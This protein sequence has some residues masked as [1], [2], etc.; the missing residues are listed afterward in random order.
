MNSE[1]FI[2]ASVASS[3]LTD[4]SEVS[5][6]T[7]MKFIVAGATLALTSL[8]AHAEGADKTPGSG[9]NPYTDCGIGAALFSNT[10]WAALTSNVIWD[11]GITALTSATVSPQT[12]QGKKVVAA[13]FIRDTFEQLAEETAQGSGEHVATV[14]NMMECATSR[15]AAAAAATRQTMGAVVSQ[16]GYAALPRLE[17][18][19]QFYNAVDAAVAQNCSI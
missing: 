7:K 19:A 15:Q 4:L 8:F 18:A 17:K 10:G 1:G 14:L 6:M 9:P 5:N 3:Y 11:L 2:A 12:C 16:P 13:V